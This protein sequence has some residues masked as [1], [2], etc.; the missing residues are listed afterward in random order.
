[1]KIY[2]KI[3]VPDHND[4]LSRTLCAYQSKPTEYFCVLILQCSPHCWEY[5]LSK[6]RQRQTISASRLKRIFQ[7]L[8][9]PFQT[10]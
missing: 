3:R 1:M 5:T 2:L 4:M 6:F 10:A 7:R 9:S 8:T